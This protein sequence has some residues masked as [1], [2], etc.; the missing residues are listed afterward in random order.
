MS[1]LSVR[2]RCAT[3]A[4]SFLSNYVTQGRTSALCRKPTVSTLW[5]QFGRLSGGE[6]H[7]LPMVPLGLEEWQSSSGEASHLTSQR[8]RGTRT[9]DSFSWILPLKRR[10]TRWAVSTPP[11]RID[12]RNRRSSWM[13]LW[14]GWPGSIS[15]S[16]GISTASSMQLLTR[17][18]PL[19]SRQPQINTETGSRL[20]WGTAISRTY[21]E[22][23]HRLRGLLP[24]D[25]DPMHPGWTSSFSRLI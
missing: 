3:G 15:S 23:D 22:Y 24:S 1:T 17:T 8:S 20:L 25:E 5:N 21:S 19:S 9:E 18:R 2:H 6:E 10:P 4:P 12:P 14:T 16:G 7:Y 11:H 13:L